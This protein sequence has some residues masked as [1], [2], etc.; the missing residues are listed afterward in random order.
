MLKSYARSVNLIFKES[1]SCNSSAMNKDINFFLKFL[2]DGSFSSTSDFFFLFCFGD[3][4]DYTYSDKK[5]GDYDLP[6]L[7]T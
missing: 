2:I 5:G 1:C 3:I 6:E 4:E 7:Q